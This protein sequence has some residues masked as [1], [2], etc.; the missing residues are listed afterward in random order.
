MHVL[1]LILTWGLYVGVSG[2][3]GT[4]NGC[5]V[6]C[7]IDLLATFLHFLIGNQVF[8]FSELG[9]KQEKQENVLWLIHNLAV[10]NLQLSNQYIKILCIK[11]N[12]NIQ[13]I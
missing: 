1:Q 8:A 10:S 2:L 5:K 13:N 6:K 11:Y 9:N 7:F 4:N 12:R 3:Q